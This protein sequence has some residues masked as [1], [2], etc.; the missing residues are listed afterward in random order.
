MTGSQ[1]FRTARARNF[2]FDILPHNIAE[3]RILRDLLLLG[4]GMGFVGGL[5]PSPL[6][7]I[8]LAQVAL[9]RWGRAIFVLIGPPLAVDGALLL[10]TLLCYQYVPPG[11]AHRVAYV[12]GVVLIRFGLYSL[13]E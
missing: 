5:M 4:A 7:M 3:L 11:I 8:A 13:L 6:H 1:P 2:T 12:G 9:S 10:L